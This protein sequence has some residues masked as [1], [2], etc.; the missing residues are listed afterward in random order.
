D[1]SNSWRQPTCKPTSKAL[2]LCQFCAKKFLSTPFEPAAP[3]CPGLLCATL[4][5]GH[6]TLNKHL[7]AGSRR[8]SLRIRRSSHCVGS[9]AFLMQRLSDSSYPC[10]PV[11]RGQTGSPISS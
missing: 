7:V 6:E 3:G 2:I 11:F 8:E 5:R 4:I 1:I 10:W 9:L